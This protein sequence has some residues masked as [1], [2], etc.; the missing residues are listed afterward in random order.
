MNSPTFL[1]RQG[2]KHQHVRKERAWG[3]PKEQEGAS[4]EMALPTFLGSPG[5]TEGYI[6]VGKSDYS[7]RLQL[8][9]VTPGVNWADPS[10]FSFPK[11]LKTHSGLRPWLGITFSFWQ[12]HKKSL[13]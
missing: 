7:S 3:K 11:A 6:R 5:D 8:S 9:D 2:M 13:K 4:E 1:S 12:L 10:Y